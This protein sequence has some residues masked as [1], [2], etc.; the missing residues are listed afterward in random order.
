MNKTNKKI[1]TSLLGL[2]SLGAAEVNAQNIDIIKY[3]D[4]NKSVP[5]G[6][7]ITD[8][9][10][11]TTGININ[12]NALGI[13]FNLTA[14]KTQELLKERKIILDYLTNFSASKKVGPINVVGGI[15]QFSINTP[16]GF[17]PRRQAYIGVGF[18]PTPKTNLSLTGRTSLKN[19]GGSAA[20]LNFVYNP[21]LIEGVN[22]SFRGYVTGLDNFA[23]RNGFKSG[24]E[25]T[26]SKNLNDKFNVSLNSGTIF[27]HIKNETNPYVK[28]RAKYNLNR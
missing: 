2:A 20:T 1:T 12:Q 28:L 22:T 27:N 15:N 18:N 25:G 9:H 26:I 6:L 14:Y 3:V 7:I 11:Q 8:K 17:S 21:T 13:N 10:T 24:L 4:S 19:L 16:N 23:G 5:F